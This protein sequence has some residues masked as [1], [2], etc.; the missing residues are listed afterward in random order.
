M[1]FNLELTELLIML[2]PAVLGLLNLGLV[3]F[4]L[5]DAIRVPSDSDYRA[6]NK[7]IWVLVILLGGCVGA[8]VYLAVGRP[9][10]RW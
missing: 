5:V 9:A 2:I 4:A 8:I 3:L 7:L 1:P 10:R 6:G